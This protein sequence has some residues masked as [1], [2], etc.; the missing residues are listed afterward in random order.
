MVVRREGEEPVSLGPCGWVT[1]RLCTGCA[2]LAELLASDEAGIPWLMHAIAGL[3]CEDDGV[4]LSA[5]AVQIPW[6]A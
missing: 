3:V 4:E 6:L 1:P 5:T 2:T